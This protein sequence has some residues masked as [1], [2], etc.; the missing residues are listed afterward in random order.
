MM[1]WGVGGPS[2]RACLLLTP[3]SASE[4]L[5]SV[6]MERTRWGTLRERHRVWETK[7]PLERVDGRET[8]VCGTAGEPPR[9][10][11]SGWDVRGMGCLLG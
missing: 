4:T 5:K 7:G 9:A 11:R 1:G 3:T 8:R 10:F 2:H 6:G